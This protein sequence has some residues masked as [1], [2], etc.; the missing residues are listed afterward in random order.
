MQAFVVMPFHTK[1]N[2]DFDRVY[3]DL[4][5]PALEI[6]GFDVFREDEEKEAGEIRTDMFQQLLLADLVVADLSIDNPNVWYELGV[7]HALRARGVIQIK[8]QR[9]Y[10]PFDV[11]TDRTFTYHIKNGIPDFDFIDMDKLSLG[12][13]AK[14]T[15]FSWYGKRISPV[16]R[17]L[18]YLEEPSWKNLKIGEAKEIWDKYEDWEG[19]IKIARKRQKPGDILVLADEA[20]SQ[21]LRLEAYNTAGQSLIQLG[22]FSLALEKAEIALSIDPKNLKS[23][24]LKS[25]ALIRVGRYDEAK[26]LLERTTVE[27][28]EDAETIALLGRIEKDAWLASWKSTNKTREAMIKDATNEEGLLIESIKSYYR[29]FSLDPKHYYSG[30]NALTLAHIFR[31]LTGNDCESIK[32]TRSL[33]G[34]VRWAVESALFK[35]SSDRKNYWARVTL[36]EIEVLVSDVLVVEKAYKYAIAAA[37]K[38]WFSIDSSYQQLLILQELGFR[39]QQVNAAMEIVNHTLQKLKAPTI[40]QKVFLFSGHMIDRPNRIEP[41]FPPDKEKIAADALS[42]KLYE[43][44]AGKGDV[45]LCGG[46]CGGDIL[47]A[48]SC[49]ERDLKLEIRIPFDEPTFFVHSVTFAGNDWRNRFYKIKNHPNTKIYVMPQEI[50]PIPL[51]VDPYRRNNLW[52]LYTALSWTPEKVNFI[53]LWN[54]KEG[55]HPGGTKHMYDEVQKHLGHAYILDSNKLF[56]LNQYAK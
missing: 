11:Y 19:R 56:N 5:K 43:L 51:T 29:G 28:S 18:S 2:I 24:Q 39:P 16:F 35:E 38:D 49:L 21:V 14:E 50:G 40:P 31:H 47:F 26:V 23:L 15:V 30:I 54:G 8:C 48:E 53:C 12:S 37:E 25:I 46:A 41:R 20:P 22:Q 34:G 45:A 44:G 10:M 3:V 9:D 52:Q 13:M 6:E 33:E 42:K 32:N 27:Y 55:D 1:E 4:I 17:L 36:S 7:R